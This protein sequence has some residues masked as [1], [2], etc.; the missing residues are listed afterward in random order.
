MDN[1]LL[2][3]LDTNALLVSISRKSKYRPIFEGLI[4]GSYDLAITNEILNEYIEI[5]ERK[6][7]IVV[8]NNIAEFILNLPN[9][10]KTE[11]HYNWQLID[12]DHDDNK[13]IDCAISSNAKYLVTND[14]HFDILN[15]IEFPKVEI[16]KID[17]FLNE[18]K[19]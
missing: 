2:V 1:K 5:I 9:V 11:I 14:K 12:K 8:A 15:Q 16:I 4:S 13:F 3:V 7:N 18:I 19:K 17:E 10:I 6:A